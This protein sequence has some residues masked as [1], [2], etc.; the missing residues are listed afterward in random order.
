MPIR[1]IALG[2]LAITSAMMLPAQAAP[3]HDIGYKSDNNNKKAKFVVWVRDQ[4]SDP[5]WI[6]FKRGR[7]KA[8]RGTYSKAIET[9]F[10]KNGREVH[11]LKMKRT[12]LPL[13][14]E[15][16]CD[17]AFDIADHGKEFGAEDVS[18]TLNDGAAVDYAEIKCQRGYS[19]KSNMMKMK[20][21]I[22][23]K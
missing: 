23:D 10:N 7:E 19:S 16:S 13:E 8:M 22:L 17:F 2:F 4:T 1:P 3:C 9:V 11:T 12:S 6:Y 15:I 21:T 5:D 18:C 14:Q 20:L